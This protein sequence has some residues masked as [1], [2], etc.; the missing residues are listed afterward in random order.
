MTT[1]VATTRPSGQLTLKDRLSRL[2]FVD[3][4]KLLGP[5]G[6]KLIKR[7]AN[8][9]DIKTDQDVFLG[10][11]LFRVRLP[12]SGVDGQ[13]LIVTITLMAE[14]RQRLHWNC[15]HCFQACEHVGAAFSLILEEKLVLGL[16]APPKP[17][18]AIESLAEDELVAKALAERAERAKIE[19]MAVATADGTRPWTDYTVTNRTSGKSYRVALRGLEPGG[20]YCSCPDFRT[21][22][23]GTCKHIPHVLKKVNAASLRASSAR[24]IAANMWP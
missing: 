22:T 8:L 10:D 12:E 16:A 17:R 15:S 9:W 6:A 20:S 3:A 21:N 18:V 13:P 4:C 7:G 2:S 19:K 11:D 24:P 14:A 5:K 1:P 23:L